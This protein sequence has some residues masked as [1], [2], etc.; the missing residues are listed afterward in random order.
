MRPQLSS[1]HMML[2]SAFIVYSVMTM[3]ESVKS[4]SS[5]LYKTAVVLLYCGFTCADHGR[6]CS[7]IEWVADGLVWYHFVSIA[8]FLDWRKRGMNA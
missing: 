1:L 3:P 8:W 5:Y 6:A 4:W 7:M 2:A